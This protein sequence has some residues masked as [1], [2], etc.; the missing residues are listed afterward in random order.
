[1]ILGSQPGL[2]ILQAIIPIDIS[3]AEAS[4]RLSVDESTLSFFL[5]L[6]TRGPA[7]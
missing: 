1:M 5:K 7:Q 6:E 4:K 3:E 2:Y